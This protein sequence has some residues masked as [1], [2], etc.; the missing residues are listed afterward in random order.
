MVPANQIITSLAIM[1]VNYDYGRGY[2]DNFVPFVCQSLLTLRPEVVSVQDLQLRIKQDYGLQVPQN[3]LKTILKRAERKGFVKLE[4]NAYKPMYD[5]LEQSAFERTR[6]DILRKHGTVVGKLVKFAERYGQ[7]LDNDAE[8]LLLSYVQ[9]HD[10]EM[11]ACFL[12]GSPM[13]EKTAFNKKASFLVQAFIKDCFE[14]DPEAFD[15]LESIVKGHMLSNALIF[16]DLGKLE[17][18][19]RGTTVYCD[20]PFLLKILGYEGSER[21]PPCIELLNLLHETGAKVSCFNHTRDEINNILYACKRALGEGERQRPYGSVYRHF[22]AI[23]FGPG[24]LELEMAVL[25]SKLDRLGINIDDKP[26][27]QDKYQIDE[28]VLGDTLRAML[29]YSSEREKAPIHDVD[30]LSAIYRLRRGRNQNDLEQCKAIF[31]SSNSSLC[32]AASD[33]FVKGEYI[34]Q[35]SIPVAIT[36]YALTNVLWLKKPMRAPDL[37]RKYIIAECYAAM[38]PT[39]SLW[40]KYL[41]KIEQLKARQELSEEQYYLLRSSHYARAELSDVTMSDEE[42]LTDGTPQQILEKIEQHIREQDL[43]ELTVER[44]KRKAAELELAAEIDRGRHR[45]E[46]LGL[47]IKRK[48]HTIASWVSRVIYGIIIVLILMGG[49]YALIASQLEWWNW[50]LFT[51]A[52]SFVLL[53]IGNLIWGTK[54]KDFVT[55]IE[56]L[57]NKVVQKL[58]LSLVK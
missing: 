57:I 54:V 45:E 17:R 55:Y 33:Y 7:H 47:N 23:G 51:L 4:N 36:D 2:V 12:S 19:F 42:A 26:E 24:D 43:V 37:P 3:S 29:S 44:E 48:A 53:S 11:L 28:K 15:Y 49:I 46:I 58:L 34:E 56:N 39:E 25:N 22:R 1:I 5:V 21:Q 32:Q 30:C 16:P 27:Y 41:G 6:Q 8:G 10:T 18:R 20:T 9:H 14:S 52:V 40:R 38:E 35:G 13:L 50:G 31:A